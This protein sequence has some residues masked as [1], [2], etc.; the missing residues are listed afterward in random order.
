M[1]VEN[2]FD[3]AAQ[4]LGQNLAAQRRHL[5]L[6]QK[7]LAAGICAQSMISSIENGTYIPNAILLAQICQRLDISAESAMLSH[8]YEIGQLKAFS[9]RVH[10]LCDAHHYQ[11]LVHYMDAAHILPQ[12]YTDSDL[13]TYYYYYGC[14]HY[15][16]TG[17]STAALADLRLALQ[18]TYSPRKQSLSAMEILLLS[19]IN[20]IEAYQSPKVPL[21]Q[22]ERALTAIRKQPNTTDPNLTA[23]FYQYAETLTNRQEFTKASQILLEGIDWTVQHSSH[24]MLADLYFLLATCYE[25]TGNHQ[26]ATESKRNS[27]T[28]AQ[29]FKTPVYRSKN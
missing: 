12:L 24:Y 2:Q 11:E 18:Y 4:V 20:M 26:S 19:A 23:V 1:A 28:M 14:G 25:K 27:Q 10:Q 9:T 22:F 15:Q 7:A 21:D 16:A 6:S 17:D 5:G 29:I 8:H 3:Q 13:Q